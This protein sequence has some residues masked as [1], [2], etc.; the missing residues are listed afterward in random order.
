M[1]SRIDSIQCCSVFRA[2]LQLP[3]MHFLYTRTLVA[4]ARV[5]C[6]GRATT[7]VVINLVHDL[8]FEL[9]VTNSRAVCECILNVCAP[10]FQLIFRPFSNINNYQNKCKIMRIILVGTVKLVLVWIWCWIYKL[11][12][13]FEFYWEFIY[14][15]SF[16]WMILDKIWSL[17]NSKISISTYQ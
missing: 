15:L 8:W 3:H 13:A 14:F 16:L 12:N 5:L 7:T 11:L 1:C 6:A 2:R 10:F 17:S 4:R 9:T